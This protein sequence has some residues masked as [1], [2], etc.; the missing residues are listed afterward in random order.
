MNLINKML[1]AIYHI[2]TYQK[3]NLSHK[4]NKIKHVMS[5]IFQDVIMQ[6][7]MQFHIAIKPLMIQS[8]ITIHSFINALK[9]KK[10]FLQYKV[11]VYVI[12]NK[13]DYTN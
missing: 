2:Q 9:I 5:K 1:I 7:Q 12:A 11:V 3:Q 10:M 4:F 6:L 8:Q 13:L